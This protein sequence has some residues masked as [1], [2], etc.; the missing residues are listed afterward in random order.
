MM[1]P[2]EGTNPATFAPDVLASCVSRLSERDGRLARTALRSAK[3]PA[4]GHRIHPS[5]AHDHDAG[6]AV[7]ARLVT[8]ASAASTSAVKNANPGASHCRGPRSAIPTPT[9]NL[10]YLRVGDQ[11]TRGKPYPLLAPESGPTSSLCSTSMEP[12]ET[13]IRSLLTLTRCAHTQSVD[14]YFELL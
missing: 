5:L 11:P 8:T 13:S 4:A 3:I 2:G 7:V 12:A 1:I 10:R 14:S 9:A 6:I